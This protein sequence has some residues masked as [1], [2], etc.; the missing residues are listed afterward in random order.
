[1]LK[2]QF[3]QDKSFLIRSFII[4]FFSGYFLVGLNIYKDYGISFDEETNRL[5]GLTNG[6]YILKKTLSEN[7]YDKFFSEVTKSKF[8][9]KIKLKKPTELQNF[10][11]R[12]YGVFFELPLATIEVLFNVKDDRDVFLL[13]HLITFI[14]FWVS[15]IYF[16]LLLNKIFKNKIISLIGV[17]FLIINPRIFANSFYNSK[18]VVFLGIFLI[19]NYYG[20][21][22][23]EKRK[24][25]NI[26][27]FS[28]FSAGLINLRLFGVIVPFAFILNFVFNNFKKRIILDTLYI[29]LILLILIL[30]YFLTPYLWENPIDNFL[31]T[32]NH[33]TNLPVYET[34]YFGESIKTTNTPWHYIATWILITSPPFFIFIFL[35][36][37]FIIFLK[38][39]KKYND[40]TIFYALISLFSYIFLPYVILNILNVTMYDGWRHFYFMYPVLIIVSLHL[41]KYIST[42]RTSYW[43]IFLIL[44]LLIVSI[45]FIGLFKQHPYQNIYFNSVFIK[46]PL[47]KFEKDYW[48]LSDKQVLQNFLKVKKN[49]EKFVYG[50]S[51]SM[52]KSSL[53]IL[54]PEDRK[55]FVNYQDNISKLKQ[56]SGKIYFFQN[57]RHNPNYKLLKKYSYTIFELVRS[58]II[59]NGVYEFDTI[60][61]YNAWKKEN[62]IN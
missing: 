50:Y 13:R 48:G 5:Y 18:D 12:A 33:F 8:P 32:I 35:G 23:I 42:L 41:F 58:N 27:L 40:L 43:N 14:F 26:L 29:K 62:Q 17:V 22:I 53:K 15:C 55:K 47:E 59:I 9:E 28:F 37:L 45:N 20:Y 31:H 19:A 52:F 11:D 61:D 60:S 49:E 7:S 2:S 3:F 46:N 25:R 38:D 24:I 44:T 36:G 30:Y 34:F 4:L 56:H 16:Y 54:K 51:G 39:L 21:S 6:N 10:F 1:M 57:N